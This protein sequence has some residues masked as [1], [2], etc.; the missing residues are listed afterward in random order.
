MCILVKHCAA[1]PTEANMFY[2]H[3]S[4]VL[5]FVYFNSHVQRLP[6]H[7]YSTL[8]SWIFQGYK[9]HMYFCTQMTKYATHT[10]NT[11]TSVHMY[12]VSSY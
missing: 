12:N 7:T 10:V 5:N 11:C 6:V 8:N 1:V 9:S 4:S 3:S 2:C